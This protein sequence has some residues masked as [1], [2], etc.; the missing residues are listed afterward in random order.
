MTPL[1]DL[2]AEKFQG[3]LNQTF[4]I[5]AEDETVAA[6]LVEVRGLKTHTRREDK[7]PFSLLFQGPL[8]EPLP[9]RTYR[10][11]NDT[12]GEIEIFLVP[13]GPDED[14]KAMIYE[15]VFT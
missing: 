8:G 7:S 1:E 5:Q 14:G 15:S 9:Q 6:E 4:H 10:L 12:L 3:C 13:L 2:S 11:R